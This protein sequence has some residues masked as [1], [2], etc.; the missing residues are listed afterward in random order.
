MNVKIFATSLFKVRLSLRVSASS[1]LSS[2]SL[3]VP[4]SK[5]KSRICRMKPFGFEWGYSELYW[6][7]LILWWDGKGLVGLFGC[8]YVSPGNFSSF[9][10][11]INACYHCQHLLSLAAVPHFLSLECIHK[12]DLEC[13]CVLSFFF[14]EYFIPPRT[15][16]GTHNCLCHVLALCVPCASILLFPV[17]VLVY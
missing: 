4:C 3:E 7:F 8:Q 15:H 10:P 1:V 6:Y 13:F 2:V 5:V 17:W 14:C 11:H 16:V 12:K 9:S